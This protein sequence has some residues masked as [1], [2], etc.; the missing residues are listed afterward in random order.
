MLMLQLEER[1]S[2]A[3]HSVNATPSA[4]SYCMQ[5]MVC[6][7]LYGALATLHK[8]PREFGW[9]SQVCQRFFLSCPAVCPFS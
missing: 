6:M 8:H 5:C 1:L 9:A 2:I 3:L 7:D 4:L